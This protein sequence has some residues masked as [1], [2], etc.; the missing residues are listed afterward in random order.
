[1]P[2]LPALKTRMATPL[3]LMALLQMIGGCGAGDL[4]A[5]LQ[6]SSQS[7]GSPRTASIPALTGNPG[8]LQPGPLLVVITYGNGWSAT[9]SGS[10]LRYVANAI[11]QQY[12][13]QEVITRGCND[14]DDVR[15]TIENHRGPVVLVG[16]SF[17]G[18]RSVE[19]ATSIRRSIDWMILLDPVPC[20]DWAFPHPG[21]YFRLP[22]SVL[23]ATC[24][25][26]RGNVSDE[27]SDRQSE[28]HQWKTASGRWATASFV[29]TRRCGV[30]FWRCVHGRKPASSPSPQPDRNRQPLN[31]RPRPQRRL[32]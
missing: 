13:N 6:T 30:A 5:P 27:L 16:H 17:G 10:G 32:R 18:C 24:F 31:P 25:Y 2:Y 14:R 22:A 29:R 11:R 3:L 15:Q 7:L 19:I 1:M 8:G 4:L 9:S 21:R 20:D 26:R 12:P 23:H 28:P